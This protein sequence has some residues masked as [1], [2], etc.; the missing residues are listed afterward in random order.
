MAVRM[1]ASLPVPVVPISPASTRALELF[2]CPNLKTIDLL[3]QPVTSRASVTVL[4]S[5]AAALLLPTFI[6]NHA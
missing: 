6:L 3:T 2:L 4:Q 5:N 1:G